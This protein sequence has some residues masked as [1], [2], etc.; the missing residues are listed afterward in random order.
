MNKFAILALSLALAGCGSQFPAASNTPQLDA[1][2]IGTEP[3]VITCN[4]AS[5]TNDAAIVGVISQ[6]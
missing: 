4:Q 5:E 6:M 1:E 2:E 3:H